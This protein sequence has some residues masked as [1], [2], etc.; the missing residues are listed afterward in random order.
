M[1]ISA[2]AL[3]GL[4]QADAQL[5]TAAV[6]I[7][8]ASAVTPDGTGID[9]VTLSAEMVALMSAKNQVAIN[10]EVMK[11][12]DELQQTTLDVMA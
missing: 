2:I 11:T 7:A 12:A 4:Q 9:T 3:Q 5:Q 6:Q 1:D 8:S 10:A